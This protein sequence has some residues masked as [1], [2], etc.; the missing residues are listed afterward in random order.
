[1]HICC[2]NCALYPLQHFLL[3]GVSVKGLWY[4]PNIHP[5]T[6]Y[7]ARLGAVERLA[8]LWDLDVEYMDEYP[9]DDFLKEV[10]GT[11]ADRCARCY[12]LRLERTAR[13]AKGMGLDGFTTSLLASPYQK[14]DIIQEIGREAG[15]RH[16][17]PFLGEDMRQGWR[18]TRGLSQDLGLYRQRYCG[19]I[20]SEMERNRKKA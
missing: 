8:G 7:S 9:L 1:M 15:R 2:S 20:Y 3:K 12:G 6:E 4:N 11:G 17:V 13:T 10:V 14:F 18:A 16:G 5:F 19:C